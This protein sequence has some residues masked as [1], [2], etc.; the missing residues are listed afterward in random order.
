MSIEV[1]A[2]TALVVRQDKE[3]QDLGDRIKKE[4]DLSVKLLDLLSK[5]VLSESELKERMIDAKFTED[6]I[7][8]SIS[9]IFR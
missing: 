7:S 2:F 6:Q 5:A 4:T 3:I 1:R 9:Y 8:E